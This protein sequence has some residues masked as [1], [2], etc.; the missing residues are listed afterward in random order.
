MAGKLKNPNITLI[1]TSNVVRTNE[2]FE[3][4]ITVTC[5]DEPFNPQVTELQH[6]KIGQSLY[7][8]YNDFA[9]QYKSL[10]T[11]QF[12]FFYII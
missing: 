10:R 6:R 3:R 4:L 7:D 1:D 2:D 11:K 9:Y 8:Y 12:F 5:Y